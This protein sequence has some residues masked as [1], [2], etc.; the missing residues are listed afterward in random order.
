MRRGR[1]LGL[2]AGIAVVGTVLVGCGSGGST[3]T[4]N[5]VPGDQV[6]RTD[7]DL[8]PAGDAGD[9]TTFEGPVTK[10]GEPFG[11]MMGTMTKVGAM[12]DGWNTDREERM[13]TAVFD[14]PDGQISVLGVSYYKESDRRLPTA[15][16]ITR[17]IV[18]GTGAYMGVDGEVTT[19]HNDDG[20]Y[21]HTFT[22]Q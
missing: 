1:L 15:E 19:V 22:L 17:A 7:L 12:G 4:L 3:F 9:V 21:T 13:L 10:D 6:Q 8:N 20:S 5:Q 16:P 14:L 11:S 2:L 18:G